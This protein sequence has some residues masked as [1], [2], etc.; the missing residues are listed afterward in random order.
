MRTCVP[1]SWTLP[2]VEQPLRVAEF[3]TLFAER[4]TGSARP[5]PLRLELVFAGGESWE[6]AVGNLAA[7]ESGCCSFFAFTPIPSPGHIRLVIEVD[8]AHE[9]VLGILQARA[10]EAAA[11]PGPS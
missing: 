5:D 7:R 8:S 2:T 6:D 9:A 1:A 11:C 4:L 10:T 3:D